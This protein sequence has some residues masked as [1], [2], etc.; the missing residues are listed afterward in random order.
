LNRNNDLKKKML[1]T[2]N[3]TCVGKVNKIDKYGVVEIPEDNIIVDEAELVA[4][5]ASSNA[6]HF[7]SRKSHHNGS[8]DCLIT[9]LNI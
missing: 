4:T 6:K 9:H 2:L 1:R 5:G 3:V 7:H 8:L